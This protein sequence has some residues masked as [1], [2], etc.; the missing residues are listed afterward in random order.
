[1]ACGGDT[2]SVER[3]SKGAAQVVGPQA[4]QADGVAV[5]VHDAAGAFDA[6]RGRRIGR[7]ESGN[8][9]ERRSKHW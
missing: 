9:A 4:G 8:G 2:A 3:A 6:Q 7:L 5:A 1:M